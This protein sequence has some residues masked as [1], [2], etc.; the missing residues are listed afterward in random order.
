MSRA[1]RTITSLLTV[2]ALL[3]GGLLWVQIAERPILARQAM[4][5]RSL[6]NAG[7]QRDRMIRLLDEI[8]KSSADTKKLL[9]KGQIKVEVT[10]LP[11][12]K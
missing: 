3:L 1:Q 8:R 4:A 2:N 9:E 5:Q 7:A 6:P 10:K 12:S 11:S